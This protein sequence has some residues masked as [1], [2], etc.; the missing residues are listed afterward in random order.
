MPIR[1]ALTSG[2][3]ASHSARATAR[4]FLNSCPAYGESSELR[5]AL[6]ERNDDRPDAR[7]KSMIIEFA[8]SPHLPDDIQGEML[9]AGYFARD[10]NRFQWEPDG[11]G[12]RLKPHAQPADVVAQRVSSSRYSHRPG[13]SDLHRRLVQSRSSVI[14]RRRSGIPIAI[15]PTVV[16]GVI[17]AKDRPLAK[18][19]DLSKMSARRVVRTTQIRLAIRPLS[20]QTTT[21]GLAQAGSHPAVTASGSIQPRSK[22][23]EP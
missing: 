13:W 4:V 15:R 16:S 11:S 8:E 10:V 7:I 1:G 6:G 20:G 21:R 5:P 23:S 3:G 19:P 12:H 2:T 14:I 9:I 17:T 22:R 18:A